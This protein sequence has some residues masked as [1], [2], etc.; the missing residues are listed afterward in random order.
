MRKRCIS[1]V[2]ATLMVF[3]LMSTTAFAFEN[4]TIDEPLPSDIEF[5]SMD[6]PLMESAGEELEYS[7]NYYD[8]STGGVE[9]ANL[10]DLPTA[11]SADAIVQEF[12]GYLSA[13]DEFQ[14]VLFTME[15]GQI[16]NAT[17]ECP[18]SPLSGLWITLMQGC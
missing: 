4:N 3:S 2:L 9:L 1:V 11:T 18:D 8:L 15:S 16:F 17:L 14:Y 12:S 6:I 10:A 7:T 5:P 13:E